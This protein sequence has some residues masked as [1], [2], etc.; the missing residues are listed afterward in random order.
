MAPFGQGP[1]R[2]SSQRVWGR[3]AAAGSGFWPHAFLVRSLPLLRG[4]RW[5]EHG[6]AAP[7]WGQGA[8][9]R[10]TGRHSPSFKSQPSRSGLKKVC[11][12]S[13]P[14][15]SGILN[16]SFLMLSYKFCEEEKCQRS[17]TATEEQGPVLPS[18]PSAEAASGPGPGSRGLP[19]D[20]LK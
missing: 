12:R 4:P 5:E 17:G 10:P 2:N 13:L 19:K 7:G 16:G 15:S 6:A 11:V 3:R 18:L 8:R 20:A 1:S 9:S 14:S